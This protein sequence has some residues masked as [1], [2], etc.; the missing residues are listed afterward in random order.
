MAS[1]GA[2]D[3]PV[4][5]RPRRGGEP[6]GEGV[7]AEQFA[8]LALGHERTEERA[9]PRL[10]RPDHQPQKDRRGP[11]H[12]EIPRGPCHADRH[13]QQHERDRDRPLPADPI[14][15]EP[16]ADRARAGRRVHDDADD[17]EV[18]RLH[19]ELGRR[20]DRRH[21]E[22]RREPVVV[23]ETRDEQADRLPIA[24]QVPGR[25]RDAPEAHPYVGAE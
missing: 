7:E 1:R 17:E 15:D 19:P 11:E 18:R 23:D 22:G 4:G 6:A 2:E 20:E 25:V 5:E 24:P 21:G 10:V 16:E 14:L 9:A 12:R 13:H 3:E 8:L